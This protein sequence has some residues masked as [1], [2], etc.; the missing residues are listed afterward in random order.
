MNHAPGAQKNPPPSSGGGNSVETFRSEDRSAAHRPL[1]SRH[2]TVFNGRLPDP[3]FRITPDA[4]TPISQ[5]RR[6]VKSRNDQGQFVCDLG[7]KCYIELLMARYARNPSHPLTR[8][9]RQLS[10]PDH[11][12][13]REELAQR[14]KI[15]VG[16]LKSIESGKYAITTQIAAKISLGVPVNPFDLLRPTERPLHDHTGQPL[17][18]DSVMLEILVIP[19]LSQNKRFETDQYIERIALAVAEKKFM[20]MQLRFLMREAFAEILESLGLS[21][22]VAEELTKTFTNTRAN[23]TRLSPYATAPPPRRISQTVGDVRNTRTD[24]RR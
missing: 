7:K 24:G 6:F 17:S 15:P 20:A 5:R 3:V 22:P 16:S 9:R 14:T 19:F 1:W 13:T 21:Q 23:S 12:V 4:A 18:A 2:L 11:Q 8:L 10:T